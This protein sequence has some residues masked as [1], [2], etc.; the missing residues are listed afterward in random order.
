[1]IFAIPFPDIDPALFTI[2]IGGYEFSLR[3]YALAYVA[4]L[5]LGW[6]LMVRLMKRPWL[7][8]EGK[9]PMTPAQPEDLLTW[10]ILSVIL[11]GR[12]GYV[13]FYNPGHFLAN[14]AEILQV[15]QGGMSFHGGFIGV[16]AGLVLFTRRHRIALLQAGDAVALAA[17]AGLFFGRLANF[18][19]G[20]LWGRVTD[21]PWA[22][23]FPAA[24]PEPRHPSQL[25]EAGLEGLL[26]GTVV[27]FLA[28]RCDWLKRP[29]SVIGVFFVGY[30]L[31]RS[32]VE[33][34]RQWDAQVGYVIDI[35]SGGLTMGQMLSLPMAL[36]GLGFIWNAWRD[37]AA[38]GPPDGPPDGP[39]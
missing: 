26:L 25:Y 14:P 18:I 7:W 30:G 29:G 31:S 24:G 8:P 17:P 5:L 2:A 27:W 11:G 13:I 21:V 19:N 15:W 9:A 20:E 12:L 39:A 3:W 34:F 1:M 35:G 37:R 23:A 6:W 36:I 4:G 22:M 33:N 28:V 38:D 32:L 16:M 10:M